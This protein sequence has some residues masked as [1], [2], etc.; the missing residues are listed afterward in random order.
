MSAYAGVPAQFPTVFGGLPQGPLHRNTRV[1]YL[2]GFNL[3]SERNADRDTDADGEHN[4]Q[5]GADRADRDGGD[6]GLRVMPVFLHCRPTRVQ[7]R[8]TVLEGAP[9][10]A[11]LNVWADWNR[12]G[13]W[14][15]VPNCDG[16]PAPEWAVRNQALHFSGPGVYTFETSAFLPFNTRPDDPMWLRLTLSDTP[17]GQADGSGPPAG[18]ALGE[19][20]DYLLPGLRRTWIPLVTG[21]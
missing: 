1:A 13:R 14:G 2:L 18:W 20:E 17:A 6:D 5:P 4:I 21:R 3:T 15:E 19:T 12:N 10:T 8:V 11:Y 9:A 16:R 7:Y